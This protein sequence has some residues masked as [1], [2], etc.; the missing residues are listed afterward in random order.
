MDNLNC[1][2]DQIWNHHGNTSGV[3]LGRRFQKGL[4]EEGRPTLDTDG[5]SSCAGVQA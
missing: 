5:T 1:Q 2:L 4:T 3:C